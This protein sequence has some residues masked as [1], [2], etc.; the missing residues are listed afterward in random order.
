MASAFRDYLANWWR[1]ENAVRMHWLGRSLSFTLIWTWCAILARTSVFQI[2]A[3]DWLLLSN[4]NLPLLA[5]NVLALLIL[6]LVCWK[7]A[8]LLDS[9]SAMIAAG[10]LLSG[11]SLMVVSGQAYQSLPLCYLG[12]LF[13]GAAIA[14][15]KVSWGEMYSRMR[16]DEGLTLLGAAL[17]ASALITIISLSLPVILI[18]M[19]FVACGSLC[20]PLLRLGTKS[21][22]YLIIEVK[23]ANSQKLKPSWTFL[24]LPILVAFTFGASHQS[25]GSGS[26]QL[27]TVLEPLVSPIS[28][29]LS[30]LLLITVALRYESRMRPAH[31]YAWALILVVAGFV[32]VSMELVVPDIGNMVLS[33]GFLLFYFFMIVFWG[34]LAKR[35]GR[36][37]VVAYLVGY[38]AFQTAQLA[39]DL[40]S[41]YLLSSLSF[42]EMI[43]F[44]LSL[45][46]LFFAGVLLV[47]GSVNSPFRIWLLADSSSE[48]SDD[49]SN[50]CALISASHRLTPREHEILTFLARGRNASHIVSI[51]NI[52]YQTAKTH[53]KNIH[54]KLDA[55]SQQEV[56][57]L[58]ERT[59]DEGID[60]AQHSK[61][62]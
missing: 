59:I 46:L 58:I 4:A 18:E 21:R 33:T 26:T 11:G 51:H 17:V 37:V 41:L 40:L 61:R 9:R 38:A 31:I 10:T 30:G 35:M 29:G 42:Q 62:M 32:A 1:L 53:I 5:S 50:A 12:V 19:L 34:N 39:G 55:H 3:I 54:H 47:Y 24:A 14:I 48:T 27:L 56:L 49:I 22:D 36:S 13:G 20:V 25:T 16:L 15:L 2:T 8:S 45:V 52:S 7:K 44:A 6:M 28:T 43:A 60:S 57:D 23:Q